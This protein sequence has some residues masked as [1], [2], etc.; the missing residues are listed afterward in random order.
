MLSVKV[1]A[2]T[3][4]VDVSIVLGTA[5]RHLP[6][7]IRDPEWAIRTREKAKTDK[8]G[9]AAVQ[10]GHV[11]VPMVFDVFGRHGP[12]VRFLLERLEGECLD[13]KNLSRRLGHAL[14]LA[15][16]QGNARIILNAAAR[17]AEPR[18]GQFGGDWE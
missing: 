6:H 3:Y 13:G 15:V 16:Q 9:P 5:A 18:N 1:G 11:F 10:Q 2:A 4:S 17:A 8:H 12:C 7:C 14:G